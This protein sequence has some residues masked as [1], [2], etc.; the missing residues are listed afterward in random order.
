MRN[1]RGFTLVELLVVISIISLLVGL[2]LPSLA[3]ARSA[4]QSAACLSNQRQMALG[5]L[6]YA[7]QHRG[8][9]LPLAEEAGPAPTYWWGAINPGGTGAVV[10]HSG[11]F[12]TPFLD[13]SLGERSVYECPAQ[14]WGTYRAQPMYLSQ[15]QPTSTYGYNGYYL[16]PPKTPG[17]NSQIGAQPWK[18]IDSIERPG[19]LFIFADTLLDASPPRNC[20]LLDPPELFAAGAWIRNDSPTTAFRHAASKGP[21]AA[22]AARADGSARAHAAQPGW[23]VSP[24]AR[25][26]S[27]G[28][29]NGPHYVPDW[30]RWR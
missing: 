3:G 24:T 7:A 8:R 15:P 20:A 14:P 5:W 27:V 1:T 23:L 10:D 30:M 6:L 22:N 26:G 19:E 17:W 18:R 25:I 12:L 4:A 16:S 13:A 11:G 29:K 9:V 2:L 21:G 28:D